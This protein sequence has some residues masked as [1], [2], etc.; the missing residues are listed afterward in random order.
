MKYS[1][2]N[3]KTVK[4]INITRIYLNKQTKK[5]QQNW[6]TISETDKGKLNRR[7]KSLIIEMKLNI[8]T[9]ASYIM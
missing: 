7:Q 2:D 6:Q 5:T 4:R 8:Q 3:R 9:P 1:I